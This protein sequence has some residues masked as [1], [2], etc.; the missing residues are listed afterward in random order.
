LGISLILMLSLGANILL[1]MLLFGN[2][3][4]AF[5]AGTL[6]GLCGAALVLGVEINGFWPK[7]RLLVLSAR[8]LSRRLYPPAVPQSR[9]TA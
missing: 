1:S 4:L 7:L 5:V 3:R 9:R 8:R 2:T 6:C